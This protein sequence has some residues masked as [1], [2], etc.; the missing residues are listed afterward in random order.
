MS[1]YSDTPRD[2]A[3]RLTRDAERLITDALENGGPRADYIA[4]LAIR[5]ADGAINA[6]PVNE[7]ALR[8]RLTAAT[9]QLNLAGGAR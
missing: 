4:R 5:D 2:R 8:A 6:S 1:T 3:A 7:Y 9:R